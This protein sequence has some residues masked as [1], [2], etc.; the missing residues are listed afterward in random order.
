MEQKNRKLYPVKYS[1]V[2]DN[3]LRKVVQ[4]PRFILNTVLR[5]CFK[6]GITILDVGCGNGFFTF[7]LADLVGPEGKIIAVDAQ[8][9]MLD[10]LKKKLQNND[11]SKR[12]E[13]RRYDSNKINIQKQ[14]DFIFAFYMMHEVVNQKE[15]LQ[16]LREILKPDGKMLIVELI[17]RV[18]QSEFKKIF[19]NCEKAGF[20]VTGRPT[21]F[22]N[23]TL[24]LAK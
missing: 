15:F 24:L 1:W 12:I 11:L 20:K 2:L 8:Q 4:N 13:L 17:G 18:S 9:E 6:K 5:G 19:E 22:L 21:I 16:E 23:R 10:E 3:F 7:A 14:V